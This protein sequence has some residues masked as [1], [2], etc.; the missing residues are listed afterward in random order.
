MILI[1]NDINYNDCIP[2]F[3][4][5]LELEESENYT[6]ISDTLYDYATNSIL[7]CP[8]INVIL[9][10]SNINANIIDIVKNQFNDQIIELIFDDTYKTIKF[11]NYNSNLDLSELEYKANKLLNS[12]YIDILNDDIIFIYNYIKMEL[13]LKLDSINMKSAK[14]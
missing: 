11:N 5:Y 7:Q 14:R 6:I 2:N 9:C 1:I 13:L 10:I 8:Y 3:Y 4:S 12:K